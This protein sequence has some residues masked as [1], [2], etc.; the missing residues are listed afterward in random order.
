LSDKSSTTASKKEVLD[1]FDALVGSVE[2]GA[3]AERWFGTWDAM[4]DAVTKTLVSLTVCIAKR[5]RKDRKAVAAGIVKHVMEALLTQA[6]G[7]LRISEHY[8][9]LLEACA[10]E[11][12]E[13]ALTVFRTFPLVTPMAF[14]STA[15]R[16][17]RAKAWNAN[18]KNVDEADFEA[19]LK[20]PQ[21]DLTDAATTRL[22][23]EIS[24]RITTRQANAPRGLISLI[25]STKRVEEAV[26]AALA[27]ARAAAAAAPDAAP[28]VSGQKRMR[29]PRPRA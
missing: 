25:P 18:N 26:R 22:V 10:R 14:L 2:G 21:M 27:T 8:D 1:V 20:H 6:Y 3:N 17:T 19:L 11:S 12:A 15:V 16:V 24:R 9:A 4:V 28:G 13:A 23:R 5:T 7:P 29:G